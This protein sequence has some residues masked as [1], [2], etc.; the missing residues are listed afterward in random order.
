MGMLDI[1]TVTKG[2]ECHLG[3]DKDNYDCD[4]CPYGPMSVECDSALIG[5]ALTLI[6]GQAKQYESGWNDAMDY[7]FRH[8]NGYKPCPHQDDNKEE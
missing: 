2:L 1:K 8:G 5:D 7:A 4:N 3:T 6:K